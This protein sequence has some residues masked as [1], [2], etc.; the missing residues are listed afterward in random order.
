MREKIICVVGPTASGKTGLAIDLAKKF[1]GE[2]VSADSRQVYRGL[3]VGTGKDLGEYD[4]VKYHLID[5]C[6]P[7]ED[8]SLFAWLKRAKLAVEDILSRG[9]LPII[10]G[11][12]GL[13]VQAFV[14]GF[15]LTQN[16]KCKTKNQKSKCI[17]YSREE[18]GK[19]SLKKLQNILKKLDK[20]VFEKIDQKNPH[21]L[22]RAIERAQEGI[23]IGKNPPDYEF[24]QL[25]INLPREILYKKIDMRVESRFGEG[26]LEE[27]AG[28]LQSG[29][30]PKWLEKLGLEYRI[31]SNFLLKHQRTRDNLRTNCNNQISKIKTNNHMSSAEFEQMTQELK[32]KIHAYA[33]RQTTWFK[34]FPEIKWVKNSNQAKK[35]AR[36]F[37]CK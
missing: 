18:L 29:V 10:V 27:V 32:Y 9:K 7:E 33:R 20:K 22:I 21:R 37:L 19:L 5:I 4:D 3:D 6:D 24:L 34:R 28:L 26:M 15:T 31:I 36:D 2:I 17:N 25:G 13:Y 11:G 35:L 16:V 14:E 12:T 23:V 30:N 8:F 1:S